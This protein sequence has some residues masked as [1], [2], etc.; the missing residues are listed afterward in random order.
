MVLFWGNLLGESNF[1]IFAGKTLGDERDSV[2]CFHFVRLQCLGT[3]RIEF[4]S[5]EW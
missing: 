2:F 1:Y 3:S 5:G 4:Q